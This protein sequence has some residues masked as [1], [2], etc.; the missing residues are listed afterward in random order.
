MVSLIPPVCQFGWKA[1][2]FEL[3]SVDGSLWNLQKSMGKNGLL[4]MFICNHCPYVKSILPR[5]VNDTKELISY[6]INTIAIS[7]NDVENY[8][9][10]SFELMRDLSVKH[11][12][13]FPYC[14]DESQDIAKSFNAICTPDFFGFNRNFELQYRGRFDSTGRGE[15]SENNERDLFKAM[16]MIAETQKGPENQISSIGC[17]IKWKESSTSA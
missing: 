5:L 14:Y 8:P 9:E 13:S 7:A 16:T 4:V 15:L 1:K 12:F 3:P 10:D 17:S 11:N 2:D 6:G